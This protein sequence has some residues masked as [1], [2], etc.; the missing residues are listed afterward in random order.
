[1]QRN[2][3]QWIKTKKNTDNI[4]NVFYLYWDN[5]IPT[6]KWYQ[7]DNFKEP[8][9]FSVN[10][11][12]R[13]PAIQNHIKNVSRGSNPINLKIELCGFIENDNFKIGEEKK[14]SNVSYLKS[15]LQKCIRKGR[16]D[17]ALATAKHLMRLDMNAFLRRLLIIIIED[18]VLHESFPIITWLM[19]A[20]SADD[21]FKFSRNICEWLLGVI[22]MLSKCPIHFGHPCNRE[23]A[24]LDKDIIPLWKLL[25]KSKKKENMVYSLL[26]R[27]SYGGLKGDMKMLIHLSHD[28]VFERPPL[29]IIN[30]N[31]IKKI[32]WEVENLPEDMWD[33]DA[34]DF[35]VIPRLP[36][37][38]CRKYPFLNEIEVKEL[39][40]KYSSS[41]NFRVKR[42]DF[43]TI[44]YRKW[45]SI[46]ITV[47]RL[48]RRRLLN[49]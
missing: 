43:G 7:K 15:H 39:M 10:V 33:L 29:N 9:N 8:V 22:Y 19:L 6:T 46:L 40:W 32:K 14:Y 13:L 25:L 41:L 49:S 5:K 3:D 4:K 45:H 17:L 35:H 31:V 36:Y 12:W 24:E 11:N 42:N 18:V 34:L 30:N 38:I 26:L 48:Q 47:R 27:L 2:L 20:K 44:G 37:W 1:M 28:L 16:E 23:N 21:N